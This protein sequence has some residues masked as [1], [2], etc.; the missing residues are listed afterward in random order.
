[1]PEYNKVKSNKN[2]KID[3]GDKSNLKCAPG[4][5]YEA[6]SCAKL[7]VLI[8]LVKAYNMDSSTNQKIKLNEKL[9]VLN[10]QGYK[11]YLVNELS[12]VI[13][14]K[15]NNQK[16]WTKQEFIKNMNEKA[17]EEF[18][19]YTFRPDS[20]QG[21]FEWLSTFDINDSMDQYDKNNN[22]FIFLGAVPMDFAKLDNL[23]VNEIDYKKLVESGI[24]KIGIIFN[25]DEHYKSGSH[26][27]A[28][29]TDLKTNNILYF[30]SY[31]TK[32][33]ARVRKLMRTQ[34][35]FLKEQGVKLKDI[36]VDW[37]KDR[38]QYGNSECGVYSMNYIIK[39]VNGAKF[40]EFCK[41]KTPDEKINK[42]RKVYFD[43]YNPKKDE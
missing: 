40:D 33:E 3:N 8:E 41:M 1:M 37:N 7:Y 10:P 23:K 36:R 27:V 43:K 39:M 34:A 16:C 11:K 28:L 42:C 12:K 2:N 26:W 4:L 13:G 38:H 25:L 19:K 22:N 18:L 30:D 14:D 32:P 15:C 35:N 29:Y 6:G 24:H 5:K 9:E 20:P 31:G 21:K 17:R